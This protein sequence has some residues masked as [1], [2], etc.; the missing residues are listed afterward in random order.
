[1]HLAIKFKAFQPYGFQYHCNKLH[2]NDFK[3]PFKLANCFKSSLIYTDA[4][5]HKNLKNGILNKALSRVI[6]IISEKD[7]NYNARD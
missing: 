1:M 7:T 2:N 6:T 5:N 3:A 4:S